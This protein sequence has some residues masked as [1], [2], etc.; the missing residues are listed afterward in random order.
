M[1]MTL[2]DLAA[3]AVARKAQL[4]QF[5][6]SINPPTWQTFSASNGA[7]TIALNPPTQSSGAPYLGQGL[8]LDFPATNSRSVTIS[9]TFFFQVQLD[10]S[11][12]FSNPTLYDLGTSPTTTISNFTS[13]TT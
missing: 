11:G 5:G 12:A 8:G 9:P 2:A 10:T 7:I 1:T 4:T 13:T 3:D 6:Q